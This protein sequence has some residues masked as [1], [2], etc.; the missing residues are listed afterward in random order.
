MVDDRS[1]G[2]TIRKLSQGA[3]DDR[4]VAHEREMLTAAQHPGV[5]ELIG[6]QPDGALATRYAG[7]QTLD[8]ASPLSLARIASTMAAVA[9]TLADLHA[10]GIVH[11]RVEPA[12]IVLDDGWRPVLCGFGGATYVGAVPPTSAP[13]PPEL[14]DPAHP[15][16]S[17]ADPSIDVFGAGAVLALLLTDHGERRSLGPAGAVGPADAREPNVLRDRGLAALLAGWWRRPWEG[18]QRRVL[19]SLADQATDDDPSRRPTAA[20]L[21][22]SIRGAVP[23]PTDRIDPAAAGDARTGATDRDDRRG[24]VATLSVAAV[25]LALLLF[26]LS[27]LLG[28]SGPASRTGRAT[29]SQPVADPAELPTV[30]IPTPTTCTAACPAA[31]P[32]TDGVV[33]AV[34]D[35]LGARFAVG[36]PGDVIAV[37]DWGCS[38]VPTPAILRPRTGAV[39]VFHAWARPG[40]DTE[41]ERAGTA[42]GATTL[43]PSN[44]GP[45]PALEALA[46]DGS[47]VEVIP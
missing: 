1:A 14:T 5:V 4:R 33:D 12:H 23:M 31:A 42:L 7:D 10:L 38:G 24:R 26:G 27:S 28:P 40:H 11:G 32:V 21:A 25:G 43:R 22:A 44:A 18:H 46:A 36:E 9:D 30:P 20:A 6:E 17:P 29:G 13:L 35:A 41:A 37:A 34:G 2:P 39:Y 19:L 16:D 3:A 45:C 15:H 47:T 8:N